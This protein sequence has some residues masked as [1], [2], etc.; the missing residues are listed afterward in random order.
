[1][2]ALGWAPSATSRGAQVW[3]KYSVEMS[4]RPE[5]LK[6]QPRRQGV[7]IAAVAALVLLATLIAGWFFLAAHHGNAI[8]AGGDPGGRVFRVLELTNA[9]LPSDAQLVYQPKLVGATDSTWEHCGP[10]GP[11]GWTLTTFSVV[12]RSATPPTALLSDAAEKLGA[13]G[14][15]IDPQPI[16]GAV[17]ATKVIEGAGAPATL[18]LLRPPARQNGEWQLVAQAKPLGPQICPG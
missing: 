2:I 10:G 3:R 14:W 4:L 15:K 5:L 16:A 18:I 13:L 12:F 7:K 6:T 8:P 17:Q 11:G 9:A 1:M